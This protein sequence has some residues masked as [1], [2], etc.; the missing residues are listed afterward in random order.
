MVYAAKISG[1][2]IL[3]V[4][5]FLSGLLPYSIVKCGGTRILGS[6]NYTI[7]VSILSCFSGGVFFFHN[8]YEHASR[9]VEKRG[10]NMQF[11]TYPITESLLGIGFC[12]IILIEN[13]GAACCVQRSCKRKVKDAPCQEEVD[14]VTMV[15]EIGMDAKSLP[16]RKSSDG[17]VKYV[18]DYEMETEFTNTQDMLQEPFQFH[19][20]VAPSCKVSNQAGN[21]KD[22]GT[23]TNVSNSDLINI[24]DNEQLLTNDD[25]IICNSSAPSRLTKFRTVILLIALTVYMMFDGLSLGLQK[26]DSN[27]WQLLGAI[28]IHRIIV[29]FSVGSKLVGLIPSMTI[30]MGILTLFSVVSPLGLIVGIVIS[31]A[32]QIDNIVRNLVSAILQGITTGMIMYVTFFEVL[33]KECLGTRDLRKIVALIVGF[34]IIAAVKFLDQYKYI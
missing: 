14:G 10:F 11:K 3:F 19:G 7:F 23:I 16:G 8:H 28:A 4:I 5:S 21:V 32:N 6:D 25:N 2:F 20:A 30:M 27:V 1:I 9:I 18:S 29:S 17:E 12:L 15:K 22:Y 31:P 13:I 26:E 24:P 34:V 33:L